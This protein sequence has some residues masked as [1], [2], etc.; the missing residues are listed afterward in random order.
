MI[1]KGWAKYI[2]GKI[3]EWLDFDSTD[4]TVRVNSELVNEIII[5]LN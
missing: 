4:A 3:S 5:N 1:L 2:M